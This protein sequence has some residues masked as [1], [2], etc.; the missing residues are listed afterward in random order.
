MDVSSFF[1]V[2]KSKY[3]NVEMIGELL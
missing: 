3:T 2:K 1:L